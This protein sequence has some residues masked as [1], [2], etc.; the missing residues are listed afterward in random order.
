MILL[1]K[2]PENCL[3]NCKMQ[4]ELMKKYAKTKFTLSYYIS[5]IFRIYSIFP[6]AGPINSLICC[7]AYL[8]FKLHKFA[9]FN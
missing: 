7:V 8:S 9:F 4:D 3:M 2:A 6:K 1:K 5:I